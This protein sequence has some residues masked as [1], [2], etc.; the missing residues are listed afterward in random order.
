MGIG[1][2]T[3]MIELNNDSIKF[4]F[5]DVSPDAKFSLHFQRT[6]R[7]P[8]DGDAYPLPPGLGLFPT[9]H[10]DDFKDKVDPKWVE[11]GGIMLP[12]YQSEALWINFQPHYAAGRGRYPFAIKVATGKVSAVTGNEWKSGL[13]EKDYLISPK[14][15]WLD[16]YVVKK[17]VIKQFVA[18]PLG[19][20]F[21]AEEQIT[22]KAEFGG[23][24][25]E[26]YPMKKEVFERRYPKRENQTVMRGGP[27]MA[28]GGMK[29]GGAPGVFTMTATKRSRKSLGSGQ[30]INYAA[31][32]G[33]A[34][35]GSMKQEIYDDPYEMSDWDLTATNRCF[36][37]LA[38]SLVWRAITGNEPPT[39]PPTSKEYER[40]GL[41][42]FDHYADGATLDGTDKLKGLKS[43]TE[44]EKEK[45]HKILPENES[46]E[47]KSD[48][49]I[50]LGHKSEVRDGGW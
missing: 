20:G 36:V 42:W 47:I 31:D 35:G 40:A 18:A 38:N 15:P 43:V 22:G 19:S 4:S 2:E 21:S 7:I 46:I 17:G 41:P 11:R 48:K 29:Y 32:M 10:V 6:L 37:H 24:Q 8:D 49:I 45:G 13:N 9:K 26:V 33:L 12:M 39:T 50:N 25:I 5:P 3:K 23:I 14:Q 44:M 27:M 28:G 1:K 34:A 16:G 30:S